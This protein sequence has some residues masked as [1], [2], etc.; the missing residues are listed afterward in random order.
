MEKNA[1][2]Y[3]IQL[4]NHS[5]VRYNQRHPQEIPV[6]VTDSQFVSDV[7]SKLSPA[8]HTGVLKFLVHPNQLFQLQSMLSFILQVHY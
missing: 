4:P 5:M 3:T 7:L 2:H 6:P 8:P 1:S